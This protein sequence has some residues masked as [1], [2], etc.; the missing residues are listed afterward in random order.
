MG[1]AAFLAAWMSGCGDTQAG[2]STQTENHLGMRS[3][4][5]DSILPT[6]SPDCSGTT[7][8][9]LVFD[10]NNFDFSKADS[11]GRS[12]AIERPDGVPVPFQIVFWD[13]HAA[14]GRLKVR[15]DSAL[16]ASHSSIVLRWNQNLAS[17]SDSGG[18]WQGFSPTQTLAL[19][20]VLVDDFEDG[21]M[22]NQLPDSSAWTDTASAN[23][24]FSNFDIRA[25]TG[26]R[27]GKVLHFAYSADS[28]TN[29]YVL[30][31]TP[32]ASSSR[33]MRS[34]D[35]MVLWMRGSGKLYVALEKSFDGVSKKAWATYHLDTSQ[36]N[37]IRVRPQDFAAAENKYGN[38]GWPSV[39]DSITH[40]TFL[41]AGSGEFWIDDIR[42]HGIDRDDLR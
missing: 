9:T 6:R 1:L 35:S 38:V 21:A 23:A 30:I 5:I 22:R 14:L 37:R 28:V 7:V 32:L 2:T 36:W 15:V 27:T 12:L 13:R 24:T 18:V 42:L 20:S 8:S 25:A 29:Q 26:G 3:L 17:R 19:N 40:I 34:L 41:M 10:S 33:C 31:K 4:R 11:S 16:R 39:R